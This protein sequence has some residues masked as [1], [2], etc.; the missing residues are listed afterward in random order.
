EI[1]SMGRLEAGWE[2]LDRAKLNVKAYYIRARA[3][4]SGEARNAANFE[5]LGGD[6]RAKDLY[7]A[8]LDRVTPAQI[9]EAA[10]KYLSL[11]NMTLAVQVPQGKE[12]T[13]EAVLAALSQGARE[14]AAREYKLSNG[15]TLLVKADHSLPLVAVRA[16]FL[17]GLRYEDQRLSGV[18]NFLAEVWDKGTK[19]YSAQELARKVEDIAASIN[20][21][22]GRN[23]MGLEAEFLSGSLDRGLDLLAEVLIRPALSPEEV[24]KARTNILAAIKRQQDQVTARTFI[25][26]AKTVYDGHPYSRNQLG[27]PETV[28]KINA[29]DIRAFY[30][31]WV[32]PANM[33]LTIVGDVDPENIRDRL[34]QLFQGWTGQAAKEPAI[35][36]PA[37]W[38]GLKKAVEEVD[39]AQAHL[40]LA[41]PAPGLAS[42]DR[43]ALEVLD[44]VLS[45]MG[46][47]MFIE[48]RDK[49]SLAYNT[50]SLYQP[51]LGVGLFGL[52][53]AFDP[54]KLEQVQK[55]FQKIINDLLEKGITPQELEGA[56]EYILGTFDVG[57][58]SY[59]AQASNLTFDV[60]Y[61]LGLDYRRKYVAGI[62]AVT[63]AD[64][65]RVAQKYLDVKQAA[66]VIVGAVKE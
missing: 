61:G 5:A 54:P 48:L 52:Y 20:S 45:G 16:A 3:T 13:R 38:Q 34:N 66:E 39:K 46:G 25:L 24:E 27:T 21:F 43:F 30:D 63:A 47:R 7:L 50:Q 57:L 32:K 36:P 28:S 60:L 41:F 15:A 2:E 56:K 31:Q 10:A 44:A 51:G 19:N 59:G 42:P 40:V 12:L 14:P 17:G 9:R 22:S 4:M 37:S 53:I 11:E 29:E 55:G 33:V 6:Y 49:Q 35:P 23:S 64:V 18:S 62:N 26:L 8:E 58:Q 65:R 1:T